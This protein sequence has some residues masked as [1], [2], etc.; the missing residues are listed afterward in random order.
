MDFRKLQ[1]YSENIGLLVGFIVNLNYLGFS[2]EM[3]WRC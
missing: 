2:G 3:V 1:E